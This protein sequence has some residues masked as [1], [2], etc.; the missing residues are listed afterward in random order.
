M[1]PSTSS[2]RSSL[3]LAPVL[4]AVL[5]GARPTPTSAALADGPVLEFAVDVALPDLAKDLAPKAA[6]GFDEAIAKLDGHVATIR[7]DSFDGE[8]RSLRATTWKSVEAA[9]AASLALDGAPV[10][11]AFT[12]AFDELQH[13]IVWFRQLRDH[14]YADTAC[15]HLEV[16]GFR[17][18]PGVT[19]EANLQKFDAAEAEFEKGKG[20]L[21]HSLWIAPDGNWV[22][23]LR[24]ASAEDYAATGKALF[25]QPGVGGWIRSLDFKRFQVSRGD[26]V[27]R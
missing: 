14:T 13:G 26:V 8:G 2:L 11:K 5:G 1:S 19:R 3:F 21:G 27:A 18:K 16:V 23:L 20:L 12:G 6:K 4:L 7:A 9:E 22:H 15:G 10:T 25:A 24:W 17:T